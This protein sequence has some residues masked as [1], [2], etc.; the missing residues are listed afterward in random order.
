MALPGEQNGVLT[1]VAYFPVVQSVY[2]R[3]TDVYSAGKEYSSVMKFACSTMESSV[4][5]VASTA[6]PLA[7]P[8]LG[9]F[10]GQRK[11]FSRPSMLVDLV[12]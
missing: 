3:V 12:V 2:G 10:E 7:S 9:K 1:R 8:I 5:F 4:Q 11:F 6:Q